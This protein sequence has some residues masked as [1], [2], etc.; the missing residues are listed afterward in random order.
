VIQADTGGR[1][2][3]STW[4]PRKTASIDT[5]KVMASTSL[6]PPRKRTP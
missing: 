3:A 5:L 1:T 4:K 6:A 2:R